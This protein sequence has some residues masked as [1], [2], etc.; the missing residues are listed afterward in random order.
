MKKLWE[1]NRILFVLF[2][3]LL[4]CFIAIICVTLV[5]FYNKKVGVYGDRLKD[6]KKYPVSSEFTSSY[7]ESILEDE[8]VKEITFKIKGRIIYINL[9]FDEEITLDKAK[10]LVTNSLELFSEDILNYYDIDF[11]LKSENFTIIG[12]KNAVNDIITWNNNRIIEE[13]ENEEA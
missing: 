12:A 8:S 6:I 4:V 9:T 7:K 5:F 10:E 13:E 3:I 11:V 2:A 1:K